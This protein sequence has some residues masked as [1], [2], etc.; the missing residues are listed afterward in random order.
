[1]SN[2]EKQLGRKHHLNTLENTR[3]YWEKQLGS[4]DDDKILDIARRCI[5]VLSGSIEKVK[6]LLETE[7]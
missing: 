2:N 4:S 1:M 6:T 3:R 7:R 5:K